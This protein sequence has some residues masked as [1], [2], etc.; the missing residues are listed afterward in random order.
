MRDACS[1]SRELGQRYFVKG[2][3]CYRHVLSVRGTLSSAKPWMVR[4]N[5]SDTAGTT[6]GA[7]A[8]GVSRREHFRQLYEENFDDIW[9]YCLR[10][11]ISKMEAEDAL[12]ET[13]AVAWRRLDSVPD[14]QAARPW[15]FAVARNQ[16]RSRWR[17]HSRRDELRDR[18]IATRSV[19]AAPDP[20]DLVA[21]RSALILA[22][23]ATLRERDQEILRL[24]AW[25]ELSHGEIAALV[26]CSENA[27]AI[28]VHRARDRL[29]KAIEREERVKGNATSRHM[30]SNPNTASKKEA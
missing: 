11:A 14:G 5:I 18:L 25:E 23:L 3:A 13:F 26:G 15:L 8:S 6:G 21:D 28:R 19:A 4:G 16:L 22:T 7:L 20:A 27:V 29:A 17:K 2:T 10:R 30:A 24:A 12:A 9:R 1:N